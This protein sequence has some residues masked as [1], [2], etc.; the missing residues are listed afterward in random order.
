MAQVLEVYRTP[1]PTASLK[2]LYKMC[3][4]D[5]KPEPVTVIMIIPAWMVLHVEN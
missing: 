4:Q 1:G 2:I 3:G 5:L